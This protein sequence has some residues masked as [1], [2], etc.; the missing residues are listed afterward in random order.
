MYLI[1]GTSWEIIKFYFPGK[2][3]YTKFTSL[4]LQLTKNLINQAECEK[5]SLIVKKNST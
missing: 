2:L 1:F 3:L 4:H 5:R